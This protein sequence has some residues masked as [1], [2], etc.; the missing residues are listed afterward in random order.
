MVVLEVAVEALIN[1]TIQSSLKTVCALVPW[2]SWFS[3]ASPLWS[4][5]VDSAQRQRNARLDYV[6]NMA[7]RQFTG[8][9]RKGF[10]FVEIDLNA[11]QFG[12]SI[13]RGSFGEVFEGRIFGTKVFI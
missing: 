11:I 6:R 12:R 5:S 3:C 13:G 7:V 4:P 9:M 8:R 2:L 10:D 1:G